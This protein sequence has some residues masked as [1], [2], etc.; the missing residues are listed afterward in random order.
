MLGQ[1]VKQIMM[2]ARTSV[3]RVDPV[4]AL[5]KVP[6]VSGRN[7]CDIPGMTCGPVDI[8]TTI[9]KLSDG[10]VILLVLLDT[11]LIYVSGARFSKN[12]RKNL[13]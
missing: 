9:L 13:G 6:T 1:S 10:C 3:A 11:H 7:M 5:L 12:L 8:H 4:M 2:K